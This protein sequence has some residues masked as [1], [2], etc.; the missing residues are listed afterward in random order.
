MSKEYV[1]KLGNGH[2]LCRSASPVEFGDGF[3]T[4]SEISPEIT[5]TKPAPKN[6]AAEPKDEE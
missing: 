2:E 1:Y 5:E 4:F 6:R 3:P